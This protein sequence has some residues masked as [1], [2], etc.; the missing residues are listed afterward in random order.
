MMEAV[1][2]TSTPDPFGGLGAGTLDNLVG[3]PPKGLVDQLVG[4][5]KEQIEAGDK[6]F[7]E[8]D[9][10]SARDAA[11]LEAA[12]KAEGVG[13]AAIPPKWNEA[14]ESAKHRT[15]PIEAFGSLGSVFGIIASSFTH[16][17]ME[18]ALNA[19]AAAINAVKAGDEKEY[20][21][22]YSAWKDNTK[23]AL[24]RQK[25]Q[26]EAFQD[27]ATLMD[28][29]MRAGDAKA[30]MLAARF[31]DKQSQILLENGMIKEWYDLQAS[32]ATAAEKLQSLDMESMKSAAQKRF[33]KADFEQTDADQQLTPEQKAA[34]KLVA[35]QRVEAMGKMGTP[36]SELIGKWLYENPKATAEEAADFYQSQ[37][38][39]QGQKPENIAL[40][41]FRQQWRDEHN[42]EEPP[43]DKLTEQVQK[44]QRRGGTSADLNN[45]VNSQ[46]IKAKAI[47]EIIAEHKAKDEDISTTDAESEY[48]RRTATSSGNRIDDLRAKRDQ[49]D[50]I[51][52]GS[53]KQLDF[54]HN[55]KGGAGLLGKIMRGEELVGNIAGTNDTDRKQFYRRVK[56]LQEIVPRILTDSQGRPLASA[57]EKVDAVVAGLAAGDTSA[58]TIR[59]YEELIT[60]IEKRKKDYSGR[61][62][63]GYKAGEKSSG[64]GASDTPASSTSSKDQPWLNDPV[65]G[66]K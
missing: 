54:L 25:I 22:A 17:P 9:K 26:H 12:Y 1:T 24:D 29:N 4:N 10:T 34:H 39:P 21:R 14:E 45:P 19:S 50:N 57:Q 53:K 40:E 11:R 63:G 47:R 51:I 30:R 59:A 44:L 60:D 52:E 43:A 7:A 27:A 18:N 15:D 48:K 13:P 5:K 32:R 66:K 31:G 8:S 33:L 64:S 6:A 38:N 58:N 61:L 41:R 3:G 35:I 65:K 55:Y 46:Q 36:Q 56:E 42:G 37:V 20:E 16:A 28:H 49:A 2:E 23:L 62:E